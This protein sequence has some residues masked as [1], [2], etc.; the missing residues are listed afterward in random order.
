MDRVYECPESEVVDAIKS[1]FDQDSEFEFKLEVKDV[2]YYSSPP[3]YYIT[4]AQQYRYVSF[5]DDLS[6]LQGYMQIAALL[7]CKDGDEVG[8]DCLHRGCSTCGFGSEY[9]VQLRFW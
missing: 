1:L 2:G 3:G 6:T 4:V 7:G 5:V 9:E 8:R